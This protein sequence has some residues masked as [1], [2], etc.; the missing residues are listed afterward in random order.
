MNR[1]SFIKKSPRCV[2]FVLLCVCASCNIVR[3]QEVII[4]GE[5]RDDS[6]L[7]PL[8]RANVLLEGTRRGTSTDAAGRFILQTN[9][10]E[11]ATALRVKYIGYAEARVPLRATTADTLRLTIG[12]RRLLLQM[13]EVEVTSSRANFEEQSLQTQPSVIAVAGENL[14]RVPTVGE[15]D[16]FRALQTLPGI[17]APSQFSNQL[18][19][20]GG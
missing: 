13:P 1:F 10:R 19:I 12:L 18:Y 17:S 3:A 7:A 15:P 8:A 6:T 4:L 16:L 2:W 9:L 14:V 20:R 11:Q 5:V